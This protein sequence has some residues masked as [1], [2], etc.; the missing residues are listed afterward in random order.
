MA[1]REITFQILMPSFPPPPTHPPP[2]LQSHSSPLDY[3]GCVIV[4]DPTQYRKGGGE[5]RGQLERQMGTTNNISIPLAAASTTT[6]SEEDYDGGQAFCFQV[7][8]VVVVCW[9]T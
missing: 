1:K 7:G 8:M 6:T 2:P 3:S 4:G 9:V 5:E